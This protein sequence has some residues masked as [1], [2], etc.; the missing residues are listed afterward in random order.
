[1]QCNVLY[2]CVYT[3]IR[4][5]W[6]SIMIHTYTCSWQLRRCRDAWL[7]HQL[8]KKSP[9]DHWFSIEQQTEQFLP[10]NQEI[11]HEHVT[12]RHHQTRLVGWYFSQ[13]AQSHGSTEFLKAMAGD[14]SPRNPSRSVVT[15]FSTLEK[16]EFIQ[17]NPSSNIIQLLAV[18]CSNMS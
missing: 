15:S 4:I 16:Q 7:A 1:M 11:N 6:Y 3:Q 12:I 14:D 13:F 9:V 5:V 8:F 17:R 2:I 10:R 18:I